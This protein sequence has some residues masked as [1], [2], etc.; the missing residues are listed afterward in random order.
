LTQNRF[1]KSGQFF[2]LL[3]S[4]LRALARPHHKLDQP[5]PHACHLLRTP[6]SIIYTKKPVDFTELK[7]MIID[8]I[9]AITIDMLKNVMNQMSEHFHKV[10][11]INWQQVEV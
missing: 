8:D 2:L 5:P 11:P 1:P 4:R 6:K 7:Q 9:P 10:I 3:C